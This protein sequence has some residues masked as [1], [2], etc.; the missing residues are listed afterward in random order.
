[1]ARPQGW[2]RVE[3]LF[4]RLEEP[5]E[6]LSVRGF[7]QV[8]A[9]G[10]AAASLLGLPWL[11]V[12]FLEELAVASA[13]GVAQTLLP[14]L[15]SAL[16][17]YVVSFLFGRF[18]HGRPAPKASPPSPI[19]PRATPDAGGNQPVRGRQKRLTARVLA[20][21]YLAIQ[22][23]TVA[24]VGFGSRTWSVWL[25]VVIAGTFLALAYVLEPPRIGT[26]QTGR[27]GVATAEGTGWQTNGC[28]N[29]IAA[30]PVHMAE[31]EGRPGSRGGRPQ[32]LRRFLAHVVFAVLFFAG[33]FANVGVVVALTGGPLWALAGGVVAPPLLVASFFVAPE[34]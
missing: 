12:V 32:G 2:T 13:L 18:E 31:D 10:T 24:L 26:P 7:L 27:P 23:T 16:A 14:L 30:R 33:L 25:S 17:L 15:V 3:A 4:E 19:R 1:M 8:V 34:D 22:G 21:G 5:R 6:N 11:V 28:R 9:F 20:A 29:R